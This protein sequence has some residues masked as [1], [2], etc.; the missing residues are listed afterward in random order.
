MN[1]SWHMPQVCCF[2]ASKRLDFFR[3]AGD[4]RCPWTRLYSLRCA[5]FVAVM[6]SLPWPGVR[7]HVVSARGIHLLHSSCPIPERYIYNLF[8]S[9]TFAEKRRQIFEKSGRSRT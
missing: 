6:Q 2:A 4:S 9:S 1:G 8:D 7:A 3:D 5:M